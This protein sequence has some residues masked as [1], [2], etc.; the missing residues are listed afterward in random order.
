L[1]YSALQRSLPLHT[2]ASGKLT[3][4]N[5]QAQKDNPLSLVHKYVAEHKGWK[6][7]D[8]TISEDHKEEG[9]TT[10]LVFY[11]P[12]KKMG[13]PGGGQSFLAYYDPVTRKVVKEMRF[14]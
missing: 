9:F 10:Y 14:Q 1:E 2:A 12:D 3:A 5:S 8:Y 4:R 11:L 13:Y 7:S 6:A